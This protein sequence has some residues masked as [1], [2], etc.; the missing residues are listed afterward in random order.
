MLVHVDQISETPI[1]GLALAASEQGLLA[2]EIGASKDSLASN[3]GDCEVKFT[4]NLLAEA[5][6]QIMEYLE[7]KRKEFQLEVDWRTCTPFQERVLRA[8]GA[9]PYGH[10]RTYGE[11]ARELGHSKAARAVG[12]ANATN[13]IPIVIPCHRL[14]GFDGSLRGYRAPEG[15]KTKGWLLNLESANR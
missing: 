10:V 5:V 2:V 8:V 13:P 3:F 1:G 6:Q 15:I 4:G 11:I 9:I 14:V 12:R 7:G